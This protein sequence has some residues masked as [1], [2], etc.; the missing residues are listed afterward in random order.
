M[1]DDD[2]IVC[3]ETCRCLNQ[4]GMNSSFVTSGKEA[5]SRVV[6]AHRDSRCDFLLSSWTVRTPGRRRRHRGD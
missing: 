2:R 3:E 1:A 4:I 5:V 6:S